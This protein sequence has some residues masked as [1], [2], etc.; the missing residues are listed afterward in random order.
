MPVLDH[1]YTE[2]FGVILGAE[3]TTDAAAEYLEVS[4]PKFQRYVQEKRISALVGR[5]Q[6]YSAADLKALKKSLRRSAG[7]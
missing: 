1:T 2:V 3:I 7:L 6:V 5:N 4:L